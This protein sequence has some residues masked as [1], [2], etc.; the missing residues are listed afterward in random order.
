MSSAISFTFNT[1]F[2]G[3]FGLWGEVSTKDVSVDAFSGDFLVAFSG[4]GEFLEENDVILSNWFHV[5]SEDDVFT[6]FV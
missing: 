4:N 6:D 3:L 5:F 2:H 1:L